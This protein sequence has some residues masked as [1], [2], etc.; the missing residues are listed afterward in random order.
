MEPQDY[1]YKKPDMTSSQ[2]NPVNWWQVPV[3]AT[4]LTMDTGQKEPIPQTLTE[5]DSLKQA[6]SVTPV[7]PQIANDSDLIEKEWVEAAK[8]IM[9]T[10][11]TDPYNK[12]RALILL[13]ADYLK[14]RYNKD[15]KVP[16]N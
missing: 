12:N 5:N 6:Q 4:A 3:P 1:G 13:R 14:K 16:E 7:T 11:K 10:F 9:D 8:K 15:V 2:Q